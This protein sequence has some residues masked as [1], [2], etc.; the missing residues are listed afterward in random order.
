VPGI[1]PKTAAELVA[2]FD[3]MSRLVEALETV[4]PEKLREALRSRAEQLTANEELARLRDDVPLDAPLAAPLTRDALG[5][6]REHFTELEFKSLI[7]RLDGLVAS[8]GE[9]R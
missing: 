1:G 6:L 2:R 3:G 7:P 4:N 9:T 5:R 8:P